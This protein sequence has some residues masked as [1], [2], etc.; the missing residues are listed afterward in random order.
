MAGPSS[1]PAF[2]CGNAGTLDGWPTAG[3]GSGSEIMARKTNHESCVECDHR[4]Q[5]GVYTGFY[6][7]AVKSK[8][9]GQGQKRRPQVKGTLPSRGF[10]ASCLMKFAKQQGWD[11]TVLEEFNE[12]LQRREGGRT[13]ER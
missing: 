13:R 2:P 1:V 7:L 6:R 3:V 10:C 9:R 4:A 5:F 11:G 12:K 8:P